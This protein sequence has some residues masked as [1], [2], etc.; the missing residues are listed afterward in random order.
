MD[1]DEVRSGLRGPAALVSSIFHDDFSLDANA[2]ERNVRYMLDR[3]IGRRGGFLIAPC[4]DGEYVTLSPEE[5]AQ[6]V[7]AAVRASDGTVPVVAG[8]HSTDFRVAATVAEGARRAGAVAVMFAPPS[9]YT[10]NDEAI[11]DWYERF[12]RA[13]DIGIM[14]YEQ[15]WRGPFVNAGIRPDLVGRLLEIPNVVAMKHVGLFTLIDEFTILDRYHDRIA[16]IDSSGGYAMTAAHMHGASGFVTEFAPFWPELELRYWE[17]LETGSYREAELGRAKISPVIQFVQDNPTT[18][19][20]YSWVSVL[21]AALEYVG[22]AGG[23]LRPPFRALDPS[24]K[25]EL[26][27]LLDTLGVPSARPRPV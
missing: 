9:Y 7:T 20:A 21:K 19:T 1:W 23:V 3:G 27:E 12:A 11:I 24:E 6:V 22:L 10:L 14:L 5:N 13:V 16:Y 15:S 25:R 18:S 26:F 4:G 17:L 2:I 8:V